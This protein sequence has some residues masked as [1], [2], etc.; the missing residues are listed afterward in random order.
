MVKDS[1]GFPPLRAS[2][3]YRTNGNQG[4]V[5]R[6]IPG[7]LSWNVTACQESAHV[8]ESVSDRLLETGL[9]LPS[10]SNLS[11]EDQ[12]RVIVAVRRALGAGAGIRAG[13]PTLAV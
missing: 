12:D 10:G 3:F 7:R 9:C 4:H 13:Y 1:L 8:G 6:A 11:E 5:D 2:P